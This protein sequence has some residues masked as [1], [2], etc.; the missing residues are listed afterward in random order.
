MSCSVCLD[1]MPL[2]CPVGPSLPAACQPKCSSENPQRGHR[3]I[4]GHLSRVIHYSELED[5]I[6][7]GPVVEDI[8]NLGLI[9]KGVYTDIEVL[10]YPPSIYL[11]VKADVTDILPLLTARE[12]VSVAAKH[13]ILCGSKCAKSLVID[14]TQNHSCAIC[15]SLTYVYEIRATKKFT[16]YFSRIPLQEKQQ[17]ETA[18]MVKSKKADELKDV[19]FPPLPASRYALKAMVT[20]CAKRMEPSAVE[21]AGCCVCAQLVPTT[22][23]S[24]LKSVKNLL[25]ALEMP[26]VTRQIRKTDRDPIKSIPGPVI[27]HSI[28]RICR[29][30]R[31][32]LRKDQMPKNALAPCDA[33]DERMRTVTSN[34]VA[35]ARFFKF[36]VEVFIY[37]VLR[38]DADG[39]GVYGDVEAYYEMR[40]K[41]LDTNGDWQKKIVEWLEG[42]H[43]GEFLTGTQEEVEAQTAKSK[44][45]GTYVDHTLHVP[46]VALIKAGNRVLG[47]SPVFDYVFRPESL[48]GMCLYD[49]A[50]RCTR[51]KLTK[52]KENS[53]HS[54]KDNNEEP[55]HDEMD[56]D[57]ASDY[58]EDTEKLLSSSKRSARVLL[59]Y[60]PDHPLYSTH[61]CALMMEKNKKLD[62]VVLNFMSAPPR[63][64]QG[65]REYYCSVMLAFFVPWR[66]GKELKAAD[67]TWDEAFLD[68]EFSIAHT[69]LMNNFNLRYEC[70]DAK[71]DFRTEMKTGTSGDLSLPFSDD[72][73]VSKKCEDDL[74]N[75][76]LQTGDVD[77]QIETEKMCAAA[78]NRNK[79]I[80]GMKHLMQN[81][82]WANPLPVLNTADTNT[83]DAT[84]G[85]L[86]V[87]SPKEW[88][89]VVLSYASRLWNLENIKVHL[90]LVSTKQS[91]LEAAYV[92]KNHCTIVQDCVS[93]F[94]LNKE[95]NR[96][97]TIVANHSVAE[98]SG[99]LKM[100]IGGMGGT[101]KSQVL[102]AL[103]HLFES[104]NESH[105]LLVVAPTANAACLLPVA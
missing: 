105:K 93:K 12:C 55:E 87:K 53:S 18:R 86:P 26:G 30:C 88:R 38:F 99:Q 57:D 42:C 85:R 51:V 54:S 10:Q 104:R 2:Y 4:G 70:L 103:V 63:R 73:Y 31:T 21:E 64:D 22:E 71:D 101:G 8:D 74:D 5:F 46:E 62:R 81:T 47:L 27:D 32:A 43:V 75:V 50:V 33:G 41:I 37:E 52:K 67:K 102:K 91:Y 6:V 9:F 36:M 19:D 24:R 28:S 45:D 92:S 14:M 89:Q 77:L 66:S 60:L 78:L 23:L 82:N 59:D 40:N 49:W 84:Q 68:Q 16:T 94:S 95:Q 90:T 3:M 1:C 65:D 79:A 58:N 61:K 96:A 80:E 29:T 44:L 97:F 83:D 20:A 100:Y 98:N 69:K 11:H 34:P 56:S 7:N 48:Q 39:P 72:I 13:G 15:Y 76:L 17:I 35:C 25:H